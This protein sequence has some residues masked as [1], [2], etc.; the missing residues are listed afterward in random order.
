MRNIKLTLSYDGTEFA[1]WQSQSQGERTIQATLA[2]AIERLTGERST[3]RGSGRT[4]SG[5]HA[6]A[7]VASFETASERPVDVLKRALNALL[8]SDLRVTEAE[9]VAASFHAQKSARLKRYSYI[10]ANTPVLPPFMQ[11][12]C[13]HMPHEM[14]IDAMTEAAA[15]LP[16]ERDFRCFM[17]AG[18][19]VKTTVRALTGLNVSAAGSAGFLG[20]ELKAGGGGRFIRI[21]AEGKGFLRH[22]V[23]NIAGT[24]VEVGKGAMAPSFMEELI[25]AG[26]RGQAG[27]TAP[28]QGLFLV[29]VEY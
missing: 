1:G 23:R 11:R 21:E 20:L 28:A 13:W 9:E 5:V 22:M 10:I 27:P 4:D 17:A 25:A 8:P 7:Q 16:G 26:D 15:R 12:Y 19:T 3:V 6:I 2:A 14:N 18:S 24:L 29:S